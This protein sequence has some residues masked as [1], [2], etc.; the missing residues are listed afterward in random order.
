M[1]QRVRIST[2]EIYWPTTTSI[3]KLAVQSGNDNGNLCSLTKHI[4]IHLSYIQWL[5]GKSVQLAF[6]RSWV[7]FP[8]G[9]QIFL[10]ISFRELHLQTSLIHFL[11]V[12]RILSFVHLFLQCATV[13]MAQYCA[14]TKINMRLPIL[15]NCTKMQKPFSHLQ[16]RMHKTQT[17]A[18]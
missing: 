18:L 1:C 14:Q 2:Q 10:Q 17:F 11:R 7:Q 16:V 5:S 3:E 15:S 13:D 9:F 8:A 12:I 6:G 4:S